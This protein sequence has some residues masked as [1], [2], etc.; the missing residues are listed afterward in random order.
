MLQIGKLRS[1]LIRQIQGFIK[2]V[3]SQ[4]M[5]KENQQLIFNKAEQEIMETEK[6]KKL[7]QEAEDYIWV[8]EKL[9]KEKLIKYAKE[10]E[11]I[12][13]ENLELLIWLQN[14]N[15]KVLENQN[16]LCG[17]LEFGFL[18]NMKEKAIKYG[19]GL[20]V[21][22]KQKNWILKIKGR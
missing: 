8:I 16:K 5:V 15:I 4:I 7:K 21:S 20:K 3:D 13:H 1:D 9:N 10:K 12:Q 11:M 18:T 14:V 19:F 2:L 22:E 17:E 6:L